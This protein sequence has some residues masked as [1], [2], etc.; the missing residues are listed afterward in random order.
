[1]SRCTQE[2]LKED[3]IFTYRAI[4]F[5][6]RPFQTV[7]LTLSYPYSL[8]SQPP[9]AWIL[10]EYLWSYNPELS[11]R[12]T[13][14]GLFRIRSPLLSES[15]LISLP[16]GTE[17]VHFPGFAPYAY[18][19][20]TRYLVFAPSGFPHS[21]ISGSQTACVSPKHIAASY[22]LHRLIAPR[23]SHACP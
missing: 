22:V 14:F 3:C 10:R 15:R 8:L 17:M 9:V 20:S 21:E 18:G 23:H 19:F 4:T 2:P 16:P 12:I 13:R 1:V 7:R 11:F 6:G 5:Y